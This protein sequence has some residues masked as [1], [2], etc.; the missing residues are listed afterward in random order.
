[1]I[2]AVKKKHISLLKI[3][4]ALVPFAFS[5]CLIAS[6]IDAGLNLP[7][8]K[9]TSN[10]GNFQPGV[11]PFDYAPKIR[12]GIVDSHFTH[13]RLSLNV[14]TAHDARALEQ[15][16]SL[17]ALTDF[18]GILC[19]WDTNQGDETGHGN[20]LPNDLDALAAAWKSVHAK[21]SPY[22]H[23]RYEIFNEPFGY[24]RNVQ[25]AKRYLSDMRYII[26]KAGL[27]AD[28]CI[29]DGL[30]YADNVRLVADAG[31]TGALAYHI[32]PNWL[33]GRNNSASDYGTLMVAELADLPNEIL[34]TEFGTSLKLQGY[35]DSNTKGSASLFLGMRQAITS[36]NQKG[37]KITGTYHWHGWDNGDSYSYWHSENSVGSTFVQELQ[38]DLKAASN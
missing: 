32:Y 25:G 31:W 4:I 33:P 2:S 35:S 30:G 38:Q 23:L 13:L 18:H 21:F 28:R 1:M 27:P 17:S 22:P 37:A 20:G 9:G 10:A 29:L 6:E 7:A 24:P 16:E 11:F 8:T 5:A 36:L 12:Q 34:I 15:L 14:E 26:D 19:M 3:A